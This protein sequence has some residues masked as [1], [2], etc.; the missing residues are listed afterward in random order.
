MLDD[1]LQDYVNNVSRE[2]FSNIGES[3]NCDAIPTVEDLLGD[4]VIDSTV[5]EIVT[6]LVHYS[7]TEQK[8]T[9]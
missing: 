1:Y 8:M 5:Q 6:S 3:L 4:T 7:K 2:Q 9:T